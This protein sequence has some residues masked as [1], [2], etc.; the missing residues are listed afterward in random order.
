MMS[1]LVAIETRYSTNA[2]I[3]RSKLLAKH[4]SL[5]PNDTVLDLGG[6][7]GDY[8]HSIFASHKNVVVA[9]VSEVA[10]NQARTRYGYR[11]V[12]LQGDGP[13]PFANQQFD[14][15]FCS[16]VIQYVIGEKCQSDWTISGADFDHAAGSHQREF[17]DE[18]RRIAKK[19]Y[20]QTPYR[21]FIIESHSWLP[22]LIVFLPRRL[23]A[24]LLRFTHMFWPARAHPNWRLLTISEFSAMFP[25]ARI[26]WERSFGF[27][28]SLMAIKG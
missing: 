12:Q 24:S 21:Y 10:L 5:R 27:V 15:V 13:L 25:D 19:Y 22:G 16:S 26:E 23:L 7:S 28:K 6:G 14:F 9:D 4:I 8:F 11:T 18:I 1:W 17:A 3:G 20:V 2:R